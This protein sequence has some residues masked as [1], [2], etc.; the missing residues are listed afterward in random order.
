MCYSRRGFND[1]TDSRVQTQLYQEFGPIGWRS[2][3][4]ERVLRFQR[5]IE[6]QAADNVAKEHTQRPAGNTIDE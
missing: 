3:E 6:A 1:P 5:T 4:L 2:D